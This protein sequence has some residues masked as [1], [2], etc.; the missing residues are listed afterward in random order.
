MRTFTTRLPDVL[1]IFIISHART[2]KCHTMIMRLT[3]M[4][5]RYGSINLKQEL[6]IEYCVLE[7]LKRQVKNGQVGGIILD[8]LGEVGSTMQ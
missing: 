1:P 6:D 3:K 8:Y 5:G 7:H 4:G 2:G